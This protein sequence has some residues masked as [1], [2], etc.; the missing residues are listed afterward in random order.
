M[1]NGAPSA[2]ISVSPSVDD[3]YLM[4]DGSA[5]LYSETGYGTGILTGTE[6]VI[7]RDVWIGSVQESVD[8]ACLAF[9]TGYND[10][11]E[12]GTLV[13]YGNS[14]ITTVERDVGAYALCGNGSLVYSLPKKG[15]DGGTQIV[16]SSENSEKIVTKSGVLLFAK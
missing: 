14:Q 8:G 5:V 3:W 1:E 4:R 13:L 10:A 11:A 15:H 12:C 16:F 2:I 6:G 7:G 9:L